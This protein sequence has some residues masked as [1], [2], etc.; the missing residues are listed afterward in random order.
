MKEEERQGEIILYT[1]EKYG[2]SSLKRVSLYF[3]TPYSFY[4]RV[5]LFSIR[6]KKR[7]LIG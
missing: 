4:K 3:L 6:N 5:A 2:S 7:A 1:E